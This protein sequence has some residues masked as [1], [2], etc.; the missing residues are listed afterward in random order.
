MPVFLHF[1]HAQN[2]NYTT[3]TESKTSSSSSFSLWLNSPWKTGQQAQTPVYLLV[4]HHNTFFQS[5]KNTVYLEL[6][7]CLVAL[8]LHP[9]RLNN[10]PAFWCLMLKR[11]RV[12]CRRIWQQQVL[13]VE[14]VP[15]FRVCIYSV[16]ELKDIYS[17]PAELLLK[18]HTD[19][20]LC[21][22]RLRVSCYSC[23]CF[24]FWQRNVISWRDQTFSFL[25][26]C[27][28]WHLW[29]TVLF[30]RRTHCMCS[31]GPDLLWWH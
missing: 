24:S 29:Q 16:Y 18:S 9:V 23:S 3:Q 28:G 11:S 6:W 4:P 27:Y 17:Y 20:C 25:V 1:M 14:I 22:C 2:C 5:L 19:Y 7:T 30:C 13:S 10:R 15:W 26:Y 21:Q 12:F 8:F 31:K